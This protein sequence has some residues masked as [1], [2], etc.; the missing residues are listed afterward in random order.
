MI[1]P[2][3]LRSF[4]LAAAAWALAYVA[5]SL[6][7]DPYGVSPLSWSFRGINQHKPERV[8]IDRQLKPYEVWRYQPVTL[9]LG[10]SR[11]QQSMDPAVLDGSA[12][13]PAYNASIPAS[14]LEMNVAHLKEYIRLNPRLRTVMVELFFY[15]FVGERKAHS[16]LPS[17]D[18]LKH[19]AAMFLSVDT[20]KATFKTI[21]KNVLAGCPCQEIKPGGHFSIPDGHDTRAPFD[22][23]PAGVWELH[24][25]RNDFK[26]TESAFQAVAEMMAIARANGLTLHF[27][28]TPN[29]AYDEH[30]LDAVGV[31]GVVETWLQRLSDMTPLHSF[32]QPNAWTQEPVSSRMRYWNDPYHFTLHTG[33]AMQLALFRGQLEGTPDGFYER[34][35]RDQIPSHIES[36]KQAV[37]LWAAAHPDFVK[38]F[39]EARMRHDAALVR[40]P[41]AKGP[42][43]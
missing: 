18:F 14:T 29:H 6:V 33:R 3:Y 13:A 38:Q 24:R 17:A 5:L 40:S 27:L 41:N 8:D 23:F 43:P 11:I 19:T 30:Y 21:T 26:L 28:L 34:L 42:R 10:T 35:T 25:T 9:L 1:D 12:L 36:R 20:L 39:D 16:T 15:N 31:W 4:G 22:G 7:V 2:R 37:K 32:A